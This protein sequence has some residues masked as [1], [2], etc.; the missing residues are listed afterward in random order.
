MTGSST[1]DTE[2]RDLLRAAA[3][4]PAGPGG[5]DDVVRRGR[6]RQRARRAR[7]AALGGLVVAAGIGGLLLAHDDAE[8]QTGPPATEAGIDTTTTLPP[9]TSTTTGTPPTG[10]PSISAARAQGVHLTVIIPPADPASGF[11][12]CTA[13]H[14][15]VIESEDQIGVELVTA[16]VERGLPFA[17]CQSSAFSA[18][19]TIELQ[20]PVGDR[21]LLDLPTGNVVPVIDGD[22]LLFPTELPEPLA[23]D[24]W[25]EQSF[26]GS[27]TF[28]FWA[29]D[30]L[31]NVTTAYGGIRCE[32]PVVVEVRGAD[33]EL[34]VGDERLGYFALSWEEP[35]GVRINVEVGSSDPQQPTELTRQDVIAIAEGLEPL[36]G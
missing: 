32:Q 17:T 33:G 36:G 28:T 13:L 26:D 4:G 15:R 8:V 16:D 5:W 9:A 23:L 12:P 24:R 19:A 25:D 35:D 31:V 10:R 11:D 29:G 21:S 20:D 27:W 3:G 6:H 30:R 1:T 22:R 2:L 14:P 34:C 18:S 7:T